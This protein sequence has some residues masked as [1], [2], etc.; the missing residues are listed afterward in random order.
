MA[1]SLG[2][3]FSLAAGLTVVFV[4]FDWNSKGSYSLAW[5]AVYAAT[6]RLAWALAVAWVIFV[7]STGQAGM[8]K[9]K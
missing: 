3:L 5:T 2:W 6:H 4:M 9:A 7:C 8:S 1:Y